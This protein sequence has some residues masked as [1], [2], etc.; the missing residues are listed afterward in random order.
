MWLLLAYGKFPPVQQENAQSIA[1]I[2]KKGSDY[3]GQIRSR[4]DQ[5]EWRGYPESF[6]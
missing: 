5:T 6:S 4:G 1:A 3:G 2:R